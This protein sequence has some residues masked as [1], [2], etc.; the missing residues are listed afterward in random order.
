MTSFISDIFEKLA[1]E[2]SKLAR[3]NKKPTI[4]S[5]GIQMAVRL[6]LPA[7]SKEKEQ[8]KSRGSAVTTQIQKLGEFYPTEAEH[9]VNII[10]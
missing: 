9:D 2:S 8:L 1:Q 4:T 10:Y 5:R 3:Y 6:V 7:V